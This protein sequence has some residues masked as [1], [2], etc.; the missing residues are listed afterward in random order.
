MTRH[1]A[2]IVGVGQSEILRYD[3]VPLGLLALAAC[4]AALADAGLGETDIDGIAC[5]PRQPFDSEGPQHDGQH[6]VSTHLM[7]RLLGLTKVRWGANVDIMLGHSLAEAVNA[8]E[9]GA[10]R[11]ALVFRALH[12]P[13][14]GYGHVSATAVG[15]EA[16][17]TASY[18][19]TPPVDFAQLWS[20]YQ[21]LH[22]SGSREEMAPL[23]VQARANG[24]RWSDGYWAGI[25][26]GPITVEDYLAARPVASPLSLLDCDIPVQA[27]TAFVV[28]STEV[29]ERLGRPAAHVR[30]IAA[31]YFAAHGSVVPRGHVLEHHRE[32]GRQIA[33]QLWADGRVGPGDVQAA[34]LYDGFSII[35]ILWLE[36]L[37]FCAE[38]TGFDFITAGRTAPDGD[39]PVNT[40]GGNLGGGRLHGANQ[41]LESVLQVTGRAGDRQ[42]DDVEM[43]VAT[44]GPPARGAALVLSSTPS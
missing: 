16:Q 19:R 35:P 33:D 17:F 9:A 7:L 13:R 12:S 34:N 2:A 31:P 38:G 8:V 30:G 27:A 32:C 6:L 1:R 5:I 14:G 28:T 36:A 44:V 15:G 11:V 4:R 40:A 42:L 3:D 39:L 37:G 23:V 41:V 43:V 29:A 22:G 24:L 10:C 21:D 18:G 25:G 26:A 20:R